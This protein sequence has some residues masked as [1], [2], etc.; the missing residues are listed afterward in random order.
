MSD[1]ALFPCYCSQIIHLLNSC[2][3]QEEFGDQVVSGSSGYLLIMPSCDAES[4]NET[5][6]SWNG[7]KVVVNPTMDTAI[8]LADIQVKHVFTMLGLE[9]L[10]FQLALGTSSSQISLALGESYL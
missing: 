4:G 5:P 8:G 3:V 7:K 10:E 2:C 9:K 1:L 6:V